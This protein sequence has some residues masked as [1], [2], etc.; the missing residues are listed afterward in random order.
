M[1]LDVASARAYGFHFERARTTPIE[2]S[3]IVPMAIERT[4]MYLAIRSVVLP[5][6][7]MI[8]SSAF[9]STERFGHAS[10]AENLLQ[11]MFP[12]ADWITLSLGAFVVFL[13]L[14]ASGAALGIVSAMS[15]LRLSRLSLPSGRSRIL[16]YA[17]LGIL[18][19]VA[20]LGYLA[21]WMA[22]LT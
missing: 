6:A 15:A 4:P 19:S 5:V 14:G 8:L 11:F 17:T 3:C 18:L 12:T 22:P 21:Y 1:K 13:G 20:E 9:V 7:T 16:A 10:P 2:I